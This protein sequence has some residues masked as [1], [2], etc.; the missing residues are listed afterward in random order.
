MEADVAARKE[1]SEATVAAATLKDINEALKKAKEAAT[2]ARKDA[3][4]LEMMLLQRRYNDK[5]R[6]DID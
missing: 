5:E 3:S 4:D 6:K 2:K 1:E